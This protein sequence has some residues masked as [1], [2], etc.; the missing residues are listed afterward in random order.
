MVK[1]T[2]Q[3]YG[4]NTCKVLPYSVGEPSLDGQCC[5]KHVKVYLYIYILNWLYLMELP[6]T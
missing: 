5:P 1:I 3:K 4:Y 6:F 2:I